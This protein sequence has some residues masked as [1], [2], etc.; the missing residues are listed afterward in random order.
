MRKNYIFLLLSLLLCATSAFATELD[1]TVEAESATL[2]GNTTVTA[3]EFASGGSFVK[4][5]I[6]SPNGSLQLDLT[7][8]PS[9]GTYKLH[10]YAFNG[11][12]TQTVD[13]SVNDGTATSL[14]I[15]PSNWAYQDSAKVTLVDV[16]LVS[17]SNTITFTAN[18]AA[19]LLDKFVVTLYSP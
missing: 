16:D 17:G 8:I 12:V 14:T 6:S 5:D 4:L 13:M 19:V 3:K 15:Q 7:G 11:G 9:A 1:E 10:L 2:S 18:S